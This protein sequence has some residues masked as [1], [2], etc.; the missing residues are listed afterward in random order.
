[1]SN[2]SYFVALNL[3]VTLM[4]TSSTRDSTVTPVSVTEA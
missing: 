4:L 3:I 1:M 2:P